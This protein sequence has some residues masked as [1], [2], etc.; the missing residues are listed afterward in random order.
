M[1][2]FLYDLLSATAWQTEAPRAYGPFHLT[3]TALGLAVSVLAAWKLRNVG[4]KGNRILLM[5]VGIFLMAAEVYKQLF[6]WIY[7]GRGRYPWWI[8]P[9]QL[10]SIPMYLCVIAPLLKPGRVRRNMYSFMMSYNLL[11]GVM[12]L[13][14]PSSLLSVYVTLTIHGCLWHMLI[15]FIGLYL[16]FSRRGGRE[17]KDYKA[18]TGTFL[19][20]CLAAFSIN[21]GFREVSGGNINMFFVGP[22]NSSLIVFRQ[23]GERFGWFAGTALYIPAVCFGAFLTFLPFYRHRKAGGEHP[24][25]GS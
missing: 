8:F 2:Q 3:F 23:I 19:I 15:V 9:F 5:G 21:L 10:C 17:M 11:G 25:Q 12:A 18:A 22:G 6:C 20:L 13:L 7:L 1:Y 14:E 4:E 16:G 24:H